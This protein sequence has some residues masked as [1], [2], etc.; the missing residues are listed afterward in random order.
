V[1]PAVLAWLML[2]PPLMRW[3]LSVA[4]QK[5]RAVLEATCR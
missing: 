2:A 1:P 3:E 4:E 5:Y